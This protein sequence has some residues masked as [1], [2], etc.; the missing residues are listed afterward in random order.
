MKMKH[1]LLFFL[2]KPLL[3][4]C[5]LLPTLAAAQDEDFDMS[6]FEEA[7]D[8]KLYCNNKVNGLS[9]SRL[10]SLSYDWVGSNTWESSAGEAFDGTFPTSSTEFRRNTG[11]RLETNYPIISKNSII[12]NAYLN[13]WESHYRFDAGAEAGLPQLLDVHPLRTTVAGALIF[14]PLDEKKFLL[15]QFDGA[16]NGNYN[17]RDISPDFGKV[18]VSGAFLYGWKRNDNTNVAI[19]VTRTFRGGRALHIPVL[20][21]NKTFNPKWGVEMLLPARAAVRRNF[22]AK[23]LMMFGYE[24][25][26]QSY[27]IQNTNGSPG[28]LFGDP[29]GGNDWELRKSEI[30]ARLSWDKAITDFIWFNVQAGAV[31]NYRVDLDRDGGATEPWVTNNLG[32]PFYV[33]FGIQ[34]VSP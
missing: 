4:A 28:P 17:F 22:S 27:H 34:M 1:T 20:L 6:Q 30:R 8:V 26:G 7:S 24:L 23:S 14:K 18:K 12:V 9:P 19:G 29:M 21:W 33:R 32:V 16:L 2:R 15:F 5:L 31:V 11:L 13:Y 25:E 3:W 10:L